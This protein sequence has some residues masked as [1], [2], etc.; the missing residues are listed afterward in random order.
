MAVDAEGVPLGTVTAP[1]N[2]HDSS[3]LGDTLDTVKTLVGALPGAL[4]KQ[5]SVHLDRGYDSNL[6]HE[7]RATTISTSSSSSVA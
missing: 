3:L 7:R 1:A 4:S 6:T 5:V 2:R